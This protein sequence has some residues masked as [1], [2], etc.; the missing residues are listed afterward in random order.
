MGIQIIDGDITKLPLFVGSLLTCLYLQFIATSEND[1]SI[2]A[3][4]FRT[5]ERSY[6]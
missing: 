1:D 4:S 3:V 6:S 5:A 2:S